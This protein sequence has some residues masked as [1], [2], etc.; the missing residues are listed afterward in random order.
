MHDPHRVMLFRHFTDALVRVGYLKYG[1]KI[2]NLSQQLE[3]MFL[4]I[5]RRMFDQ[6]N[7]TSTSKNRMKYMDFIELQIKLMIQMQ[8]VFTAKHSLL[9]EIFCRYLVKPQTRDFESVDLTIECRDVIKLFQDS[10]I[11][12]NPDKLSMLYRVLERHH[13]ISED[14]SHVAGEVKKI[15]KELKKLENKTGDRSTKLRIKYQNKKDE[16]LILMD[17]RLM[18]LYNTEITFHEFKEILVIYF[19]KK[20][21]ESKKSGKKGDK[22]KSFFKK[23]LKEFIEGNK[24]KCVIKRLKDNRTWKRTEKDFLKDRL[25][26]RLEE[27][28]L[29]RLAQQK[30]AEEE[31]KENR[32]REYMKDNDY[33]I[34]S[35]IEMANNQ[36]D[37][38]SS[39]ESNF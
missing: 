22:L 2:E 26:E 5:I 11:V 29:R 7:T 30:K 4:T 21:A 10:G 15:D 31:S 17:E 18:L 6:T 3:E 39:E 20:D 12:D 32:E 28:R 36:D 37:E 9:I 38:E 23:K 34:T 25:E 13:D 1:R 27:E 14:F 8:D 33:N 16:K 24:R 19:L 35:D